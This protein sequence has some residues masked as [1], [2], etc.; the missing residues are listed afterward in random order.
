MPPIPSTSSSGCAAKTS[1]RV[2]RAAPPRSARQPRSGSPRAAGRPRHTRPPGLGD[3]EFTI[4][5]AGAASSSSTGRAP[6]TITLSSPRNVNAPGIGP[7][8]SPDPVVEVRRTCLP[9]DDPVGGD[10]LRPG[11]RTARILGD[12]G[13]GPATSC[14]TSSRA[15]CDMRI[16]EPA[17]SVVAVSSGAMSTTTWPTIAPES[18]VASTISNSVTPVRA[19]PARIAHGIGARPRWRGK[20]R[21]MHSEH[22]FA[23]E[24]DERITDELRPADD[25]D[26]LRLELAD[27]VQRVRRVDVPR[28]DAARRRVARRVRRTR[29]GPSGSGRSG[30]A[31]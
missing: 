23:G 9:V 25:E 5:P 15:S 29:T 12:A 7:R 3:S 13:C 1:T 14:G 30:R 21:R 2:I 19:R 27:R 24:R 4:V 11:A 16:G 17:K 20:Q 22:A 26:Q 28:L 10:A 8:L 18:A 31:A 6:Q